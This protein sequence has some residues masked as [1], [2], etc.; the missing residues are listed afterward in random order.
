MFTGLVSDI[1]EVIRVEPRG[2]EMLRL[3][4]ACSYELESIA[5]GASIACGGP[6]LTVTGMGL[7]ADNR[8]WFE[9][10]AA[11]ETL[12]R[13][14][15]GQW[16]AGTRINLERSLKLGDELGGHW[17]TGHVDGI[18]E[19]ITRDDGAEYARFDLRVPK[20]LAPFIA[21]KG[22]V[23]LD[24]T[25]LTVNSVEDDRF[26]VLLIPHSLAVT[27]WGERRAGDKVN[28]EVDLMAR[29]VARLAA[30]RSLV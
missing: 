10:D 19:I 7:L 22:S 14:T 3:A 5:L 23:C 15:V 25:S 27:T 28:L 30:A 1:G 20:A 17:V 6:C 26:S 18:A 4:I 12:A 2:N 29:Y 16:V 9:V 8:T 11:P 13:T 24:G 21:E